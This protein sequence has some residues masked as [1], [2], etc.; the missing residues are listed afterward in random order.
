MKCPVCGNSAQGSLRR[1]PAPGAAP[2]Y[3]IY[4]CSN[5]LS[6]FADPMSPAEAGSYA[7]SEFYGWRD[8]FDW[9]LAD[10]GT[11]GGERL[12]EI[13]CGEGALLRRVRGF[14]ACGVD[15]NES[16]VARGRASGLDL[17]AAA[18]EEFLRGRGGFSVIAAFHVLE[19]APD[20]PGLL[21]LARDALNENGR[22]FLSVPNPERVMFAE[23]L[24]EDWDKP[25]HHLVRFSERGLRL[26][27]ERCGFEP[28]KTRRVPW[29]LGYSAGR[30]AGY[31]DYRAWTW[32]GLKPASWS[33]PFRNLFRLVMLVP[34]FLG[35]PVRT[36]GAFF[37]GGQ[38]LYVSARKAKGGAA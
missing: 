24:R 16:A 25:P 26:L 18:A 37:R 2:G 31:L 38:S 9:F 36:A 13:G 33:R 34:V 1:E 14:E 4:G 5:C 11:G 12:L 22:L 8:E 32:L 17:Y 27:L 28:E 19:H 15:F 10:V 7:G 6:S 35:A 21:G 3:G 23:E 29:R 20:P 30:L